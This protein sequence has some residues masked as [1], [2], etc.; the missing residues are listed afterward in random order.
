MLSKCTYPNLGTLEP[1]PG[2]SSPGTY[3]NLGTLEPILTSEPWNPSKPRNLGTYPNLGT[4]EPIQTSE[5]IGTGSRNR[6]RNLPG[7]RFIH[8]TAPARPAHTEI[9]IVQR[10]HSILLLGNY[11]NNYK[12]INL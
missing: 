7:T 2:T 1:V 9:Y 6:S 10:P 3:P 12:I 11:I 4:L 5:P 8:G